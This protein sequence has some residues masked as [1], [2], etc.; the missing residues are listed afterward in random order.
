MGMA[1]MVTCCLQSKSETS[2]TGKML[3]MP[4]IKGNV[5]FNCGVMNH[6]L[7]Q[8]FYESLH[9]PMLIQNSFLRREKHSTV[10]ILSN[11]F[12]AVCNA[13]WLCIFQISHNKYN[14]NNNN[15]NYT[16]IS[17]SVR[18]LIHC[19]P[20]NRP[21]TPLA[22]QVLS[23]SAETNILFELHV[24]L[25]QSLCFHFRDARFQLPVIQ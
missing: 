19:I 4:Q 16:W 13:L 21:V 24:N 25:L 5:R 10:H 20:A 15:N 2:S 3:K 7:L 23:E 11:V 17:I 6:L 9:F 18:N 14:N 12:K 1:L 8:N 22:L